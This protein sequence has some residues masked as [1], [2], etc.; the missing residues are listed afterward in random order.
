M[1]MPRIYGGD[2][3]FFMEIRYVNVVNVSSVNMEFPTEEHEGSAVRI[4]EAATA[5]LVESGY[6]GLSMRKLGARVGL[7]QAAIYRHYRDK[8]DLVGKIIESGYRRLLAKIEALPALGSD[9]AAELAAGIRAYVDFALDSPDLFK[10][11]LL[12]DLGPAKGAIEAF[13]PGVSR[14][15]RT[16][17]LLTAQIG[18]GVEAGLFAPCDLELTA[19][20]L[21]SAMFGLAARMAMEGDGPPESRRAVIERSIELLLSGLAAGPGSREET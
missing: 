14:R 6:E 17:A 18:R 10:A 9:P 2:L 19:Q 5:M 3:T 16:F 8:A 4:L 11:V 21:W 15:R 7:S 1:I 20:A 13:T 12:Q